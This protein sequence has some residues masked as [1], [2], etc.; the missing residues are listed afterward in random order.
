MKKIF[1]LITLCLFTVMSAMAA[2]GDVTTNANIDFSNGI[3][4]GVVTGT[5]NSMTVGTGSGAAA[6]VEGG[7]FR[8]GDVTNV[9]TI[10]EGERAGSRDVVNV[11]FKMAWGNKN[12]MGSSFKLKDAEGTDICSFS[13]CRWGSNANTMNI[14]MSGLTGSAYNNAPI[15]DRYTIFDIAIDYASKTITTKVSC[16]NPKASNTFTA[17][18]S[19]TNPVAS[20]ET[21]GFNVGGN[22][23]RADAF[24]DLLIQ[25]VEGNYDVASANFTVKYVNAE[26]V[27]IKDADDSRTGDVNSNPILLGTDKAAIYTDGKK[28][29]YASDDASSVTIASDNSTVVTVTFNE[30]AKYNYAIKAQDANGNDLKTLAEGATFTDEA[31][32]MYIPLNVL[33]DGKLYGISGENSWRNY[34]ITSQNQ[35]EVISYPNVVE[36]VVAYV[37]GEDP[38]GAAVSTPSGNQQLASCGHMGRGTNLAIANLPAGEYKLYLH[39]INTNASAHAVTINA[40]E[41]EVANFSLT[42]RPT[43]ESENFTLIAPTDITFTAPASSTSGVDWIYIVKTGEASMSPAINAAGL[44]TFSAAFPAKIEGAKVYVATLGASTITA[45]LVES[46]IVPAGE[47][48]ILVQDGETVTATYT[49]EE[50]N[51]AAFAANQLVA[52]TNADGSLA[53]VQNKAL[54][55]SGNTFMT[56]TG[57]TLAANK[58]YFEYD[59]NEAKTSF[60]IVFDDDVTAADVV[61]AEPVKAATP[62]KY[63]NAKG[64]LIIKGF[65]ALGQ[66]VK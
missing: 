18:L 2:E 35:T 9:V 62:V 13:Y 19:N 42:A 47:G 49:S 5:K 20:F 6:R 51:E 8:Q 14:N 12:G 30:V 65:N 17:T 29:V 23:D 59:V 7:W 43:A 15:L 39:Y 41:T 24:K 53:E 44:G 57:T 63:I 46:G 36:N 52:T 37:E 34:T 3:V 10:A 38:A 48:V 33:K 61:E 55:L 1:T 64:Q 16:Q 22:T 60:S 54:V 26:G 66:A 4:D 58:A 28:Y 31:V 32:T 11:S 27:E 25:T 21:A 50:A 45:T 56:Y 40:G